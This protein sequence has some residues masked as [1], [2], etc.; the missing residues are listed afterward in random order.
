MPVFYKII[1][2]L[3]RSHL[4]FAIT[5]AVQIFWQTKITFQIHY[6]ER[7]KRLCLKSLKSRL[8]VVCL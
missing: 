5:R 6:N 7:L 1:G 2:K 3:A 8:Y 4:K